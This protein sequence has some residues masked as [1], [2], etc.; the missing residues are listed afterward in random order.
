MTKKEAP[1]DT[2]PWAWTPF[3]ERALLAFRIAVVC[4]VA[5][6][7]FEWATRVHAA[8]LWLA[9]STG[10]RPLLSAGA[11][12]AAAALGFVLLGGA[13]WSTTA[14]VEAAPPSARS[15]LLLGAQLLAGWAAGSAE[16]LVLACLQAPFL[17]AG[18]GLAWFLAWAGA[19]PVAHAAVAVATALSGLPESALDSRSLPPL[20]ARALESLC[21]LAWMAG[22]TAL[23]WTAARA[24]RIWRELLRV[25]AE[26]RASS[27][28]L[29]GSAGIAER[30]AAAP[31]VD[32]MLGRRLDEI[33]RLLGRARRESGDEAAEPLSGALDLVQG[34][35]E[36]LHGGAG[37]ARPTLPLGPALRALV[38]SSSDLETELEL[39]DDLRLTPARTE[40]L[41]DCA[42]VALGFAAR[43]GGRPRVALELVRMGGGHLLTV[44]VDP[45]PAPPS[46]ERELHGLRERLRALGGAL[47]AGPAGGA[48]RL[49]AVLPEGYPRT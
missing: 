20:A 40:I 28:L 26:L 24:V 37:T 34:L 35:R 16:L 21:V 18:R 42:R 49:Q 13:A 38:Q 27:E 12:W 15:L 31:E 36:R 6:A 29:A 46:G 25:H 44:S 47:R 4:L 30:L 17:L 1:T 10:S 23:G 2:W 3:E 22:G 43:T 32:E 41:F 48:F 33:G 5:L 19:L 39:P 45:C 14:R 7:A 11:V 9:W 8:K